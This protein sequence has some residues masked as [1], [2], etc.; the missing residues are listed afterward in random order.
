MAEDEKPAPDIA[1]IV[2]PGTNW[3][4]NN[5]N[6]FVGNAG[7]LAAAVEVRFIYPPPPPPRCG[8]SLDDSDSNG[9]TYVVCQLPQGHD[10]P[11]TDDVAFTPVYWGPGAGGSAPS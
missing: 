4:D 7:T 8:D 5:R 3:G 9:G 2:P 6:F 1:V 11:H 10:G